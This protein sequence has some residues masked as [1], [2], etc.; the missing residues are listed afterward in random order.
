MELSFD[1][2]R[3]YVRVA[4][5]GNSRCIFPDS[6]HFFSDSDSIWFFI[7]QLCSVVPPEVYD[8]IDEI[9]AALGVP[10]V[11]SATYLPT[12]LG[13]SMKRSTLKA[14]GRLVI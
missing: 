5:S 3:S 2:N 6:I 9:I 7:V 11:I 12:P 14:T 13:A 10:K 4:M 1:K 8:I